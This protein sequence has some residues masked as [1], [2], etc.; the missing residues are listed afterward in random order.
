MK[1]LH[2]KVPTL[3]QK[4]VKRTEIEL[5]YLNSHFKN[6]HI[7]IKT[8]ILKHLYLTRISYAYKLTLKN[9]RNYQKIS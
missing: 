3:L 6:W 1:Y 9:S 7:R 2:S 4:S 8:F 5:N